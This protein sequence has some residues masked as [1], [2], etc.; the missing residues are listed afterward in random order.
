MQKIDLACIIDDDPIFVYGIQKMIA[1]GE[2]CNNF[3]VY[4]NGQ[5]ALDALTIIIKNKEKLPEVILLDLNMPI[6]DGWQFL[7]EFTKVK[8]DEK[9]MIYIVSS[10][11]DPTDV[12][13]AKSYENVSN[14]VVKPIDLEQLRQLFQSV[15]DSLQNNM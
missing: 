3:M 14:Y 11:I 13:R 9:I 7:D 10:S 8:L 15:K 2:F 4:S 12:L 6:L 5:E 1:M